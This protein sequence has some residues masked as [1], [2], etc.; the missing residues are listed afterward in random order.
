[1][2]EKVRIKSVAEACRM[3]VME[4]RGRDESDDD[5]SDSEDEGEGDDEDDGEEMVDVIGNGNAND[6]VNAN[7]ME[8]RETPG[9]WEME[10][11][12]VYERTIQILGDELGRQG[13][14]EDIIDACQVS[15]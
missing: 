2:T 1:M 12:R 15:T 10:A 7:V 3:V 8:Y 6:N 11:A 13:F 4:V 14:G 5:D 9:R